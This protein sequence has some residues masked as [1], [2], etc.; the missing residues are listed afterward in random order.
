MSDQLIERRQFGTKSDTISVLGFGGVI[1]TNTFGETAGRY[2]SEAI[3][4]GV[5]YF[6][7]G[8]FYGNAQEILGPALAPYREECFLA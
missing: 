7:V 2:V 6:D 3:E 5:N 4:A 8:P 1:V